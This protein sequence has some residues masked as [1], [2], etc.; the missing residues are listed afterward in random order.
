MALRI[1]WSALEGRA[2]YVMKGDGFVINNYAH[3]SFVRYISGN[4]L[5]T[6]SYEYVDE[7]T[8]RG[9]RFFVFRSYSIQVQ[10]PTELAWDDGV[11]LNESE[12]RTV[13]DQICRTLR[14]YKKQPCRVVV[15]DRLYQKLEA[16]QRA[17]KAYRKDSSVGDR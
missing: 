16:A 9:R 8:E 15:D 1:D 12:S 2:F 3:P 10:V 4:R 7:T 14:Q 17:R 13:L 6:L 11:P 5:L